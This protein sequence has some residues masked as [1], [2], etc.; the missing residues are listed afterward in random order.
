MVAAI[1]TEMTLRGARGGNVAKIVAL[2]GGRITEIR[3]LTMVVGVAFQEGQGAVVA[4]TRV[5]EALRGSRGAS[6]AAGTIETTLR[7]G[8]GAVAATKSVSQF[9]PAANVMNM[10]EKSTFAIRLSCH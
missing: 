9:A 1:E 10:G 2:Q 4:A 7:E 6:E 8:R 3:M 5:E